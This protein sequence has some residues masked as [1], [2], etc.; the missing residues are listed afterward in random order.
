MT[1]PYE[2]PSCRSLPEALALIAAS[3]G[4][5]ISA[6]GLSHGLAIERGMLSPVFF[7]EAA[8]RA[9]FRLNSIALA[10]AVPEQCPMLLLHKDG[11]A[12]VVIAIKPGGLCIL[13]SPDA[14]AVNVLLG[15]LIASDIVECWSASPAVRRDTRSEPE[16][17]EDK[18]WLKNG[19]KLGGRTLRPLLAATITINLLA[20]AVPLISMNVL[21]RVVS[22]GAFD[23][24]WALSIAGFAAIVFDFVLRTLRGSLIDRASAR[25]DVIL[26]NTIF[27]KVLGAKL[28]AARQSVGVQVNSLRE[29]ESIREIYNS[30]AVTALGDLPFAALFFAVIWLV[31]G[32]LVLV[33]LL[34]MPL[35]LAAGLFTQWR[36]STL[37]AEHLKDAAHKNAVAIEM[38][39]G[40]ETLK[41]HGSESWAAHKWEAAVA[42]HV[43]HSIE[44]RWWTALSGNMIIALQGLTTI[45]ILITGV[46]L[47]IGNIISPGA[48]FAATMLAGRSLMPIA[49]LAALMSKYHQARSA[50]QAIRQLAGAEQERPPGRQFINC[51][52]QMKKLSLENVEMA[53][54][55]GRAPAIRVRALSISPG[56]K[57]GIVGGIGS[58]KST[59]L[60]LILG[61]RQPTKGSI[62]MGGI[63]VQELDP[64]GYR[65]HFGSVFQD[66]AF[67]FGTLYE[68]IC[69][70]RPAL[71]E[72][73][74]LEA[75][76]MSGALDWIKSL[77]AGFATFVTEGGKNLSSGQ[78]QTLALA[79]A[80]L[81]KPQA[82]LLDEPS[83]N[84]DP[85]SEMELVRKL[86]E[87]GPDRTLIV[88]S[89]RP[90]LIDACDRIIVVDSGEILMDG[91]KAIVLA[92]LK[93]AI[94]AQRTAPAGAA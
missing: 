70:Q 65:R 84:M 94:Q 43:G 57:V 4:R 34:T 69:F 12:T 15:H 77:P 45:A 14:T 81:G 88:V 11:R 51:P 40:I 24:L 18:N 9:G 89:H 83:S 53:Y 39:S 47:V 80:F 93:Q 92:R 28:A 61:L 72:A 58:G 23:T 17:R 59:L 20:L 21:D 7:G 37:S 60:Q 87:I 62:T 90:A 42:G 79:R 56:E 74:L 19:L 36:L 86:R 75:A 41:A 91:D 27:G 54:A 82:L 1:I 49:Q 22:H 68:N 71:G 3:Q 10:N 73:E 66:E 31:A 6:D 30:A 50:Y 63:P 67:Y 85:R 46:Y 44:M 26:S 2:I 33:P 38:L 78:R 48:L 35:L 25:S 55:E 5:K 16:A 76:G 13:L 64:L 8:A 29:Y 32:P 52:P